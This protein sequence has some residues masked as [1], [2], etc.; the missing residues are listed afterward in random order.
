M[1]VGFLRH[2]AQTSP[3]SVGLASLPVAPTSWQWSGMPRAFTSLWSIGYKHL[4]YLNITSWN[5][6]TLD[7]FRRMFITETETPQICPRPWAPDFGLPNHLQ[8]LVAWLV[9]WSSLASHL[10]TSLAGHGRSSCQEP[11]LLALTFSALLSTENHQATKATVRCFLRS[12]PCCPPMKVKSLWP[13][14]KTNKD[15][16]I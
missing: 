16:R 14:K 4:Q 7:L 2:Q 12:R 3:S 9:G 6:W 1:P 15:W 13:A 8:G 11:V 5:C 10:H